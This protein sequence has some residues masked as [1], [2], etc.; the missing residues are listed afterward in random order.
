MKRVAEAWIPTK[1]AKFKMITYADQN[2]DRMPH[3]AM[4]HIDLDTENAVLVRIHSEC[5]TGDLFHSLRCDCGEQLDKAFQLVSE[6][7]G[8]IIYLRQEGRGIGLINKLE[9]YNL[10]DK[11]VDTV[12]ANEELGFHP[13]ERNYKDAIEIL[14]DLGIKKVRLLTNNP[15]KAKEIE[16][17]EISL[18]ERVPIVIDPR[19]ENS[20][21]LQVKKDKMGHLFD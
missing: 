12:E 21:Y 14:K 1:L 15:E 13:D 5:M 2:Q 6:D 10:Q 11:G 3:V 4:V 20:R 18:V 9:A 19:E 8:V 16:N 7:P 17:S